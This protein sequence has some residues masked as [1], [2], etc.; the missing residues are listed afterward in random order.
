MLGEMLDVSRATGALEIMTLPAVLLVVAVKLAVTVTEVLESVA[1]EIQEVMIGGAL[2]V[3]N[4]GIL[5]VITDG[6]L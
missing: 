3:T 4:G 1:G 6:T 5:H 2:D